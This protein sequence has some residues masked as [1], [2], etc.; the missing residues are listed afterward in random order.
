MA[1]L[2]RA[3]QDHPQSVRPAVNLGFERLTQTE[4]AALIDRYRTALR[5]GSIPRWYAEQAL[6]SLANVSAEAAA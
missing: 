4:R 1:T 2:T 5:T 3:I 6:A